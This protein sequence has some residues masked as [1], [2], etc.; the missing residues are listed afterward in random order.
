MFNVTDFLSKPVLALYEGEILGEACDLIFDEKLKTLNY[1]K[2]LDKENDVEMYVKPT[3]IYNV[4]KNAITIKNKS[5]VVTQPEMKKYLHNVIGA[6]AF[7]IDGE[8]VG[9]L[10]DIALNNLRG[11]VKEF[12]FG[13]NKIDVSRLASASQNS[14]VFLSE[15]SKVKLSRFKNI[16]HKPKAK[17]VEPKPSENL[18]V[19]EPE[20]E[21]KPVEPVYVEN[22]SRG[23]SFI[24]GKVCTRDIYGIND[25]III[26]KGS[27]INNTVIDTATKYGKLKELMLF[28]E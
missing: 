24:V 16:L 28:C 17:K 25:I 19:A 26:K 21:L 12:E 9:K 18:V 3:A 11:V 27:R 5:H 4:G 2:I 20:I 8:F 23:I 7:T 22:Q 15:N 1:I 6:K 13:D 10:T 14:I